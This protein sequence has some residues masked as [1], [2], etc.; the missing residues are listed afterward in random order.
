MKITFLGTGEAFDENHPNVS[1]LV[2]GK[3]TILVDCGYSVPNQFWKTNK[4]IDA[5]YVSHFHCDHY[6][7]I[8][9]VLIRMVEEQRRNPLIIIGPKGVE[10][11]IKNL[12]GQGYKN[13]WEHMFKINFI[14][15]KQGKKILLGDFALTFARTKHQ[16]ENNAIRIQQ[17]KKVLCYSGDGEITK[18]SRKLFMNCGMLI[19]ESQWLDK[20]DFQHSSLKDVLKLKKETKAKKVFIVHIHRK[21]RKKVKV[22][23]LTVAKEGQIIHF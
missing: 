11:K 22:K 8:V 19:H 7:G 2:E 15:A 23:E 1:F 20:N 6:F 14:E 13:I 5:I 21:L 4:Q 18:E 3:K 12:S 10:E 9:P 17:G 16:V